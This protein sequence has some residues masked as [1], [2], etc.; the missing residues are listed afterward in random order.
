MNAFHDHSF[1]FY[2]EI[3]MKKIE[4]C[5]LDFI[6]DCGNVWPQS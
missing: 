6:G 1:E 5:H 2:Y 3:I 4:D